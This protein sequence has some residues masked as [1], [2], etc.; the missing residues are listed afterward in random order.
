MNRN[1][2]KVVFAL[3]RNSRERQ[4]QTFTSLQFL[5][6]R[7]QHK[8]AL[9]PGMETDRGTHTKTSSQGRGGLTDLHLNHE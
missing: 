9:K 3:D 1:K 6:N 2:S 5:S 4:E 8:N 7:C